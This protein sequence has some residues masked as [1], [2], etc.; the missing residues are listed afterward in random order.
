MIRPWAWSC[1][2]GRAAR[3]TWKMP[4]R[5]VAMISCHNRSTS[6]P[7]SSGVMPEVP[8]LFTRMSSRPQRLA[9]AETAAATSAPRGGAPGSGRRH[10]RCRP[11]E[12]LPGNLFGAGPVVHGAGEDE[13]E[14]REAIDVGDHHRLDLR[15]AGER[16]DTALGPAA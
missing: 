1:M 8:A 4:L 14:V 12:F 15:L 13:E 2:W 5:F 9:T 7:P 3:V 6:S 16:H 11:S 10:T